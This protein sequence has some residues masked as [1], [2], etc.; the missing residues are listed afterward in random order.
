MYTKYVAITH[1]KELPKMT[2]IYTLNLMADL[3]LNINLD[4]DLDF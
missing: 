1:S 4:T 2:M 3:E